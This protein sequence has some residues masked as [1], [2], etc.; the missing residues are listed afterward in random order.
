MEC[1]SWEASGNKPATISLDLP[2]LQSSSSLGTS[3]F[4]Q[5]SGP[6]QGN[7]FWWVFRAESIRSL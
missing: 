3:G 6:C 5:L 7:M 1:S 4:F 2:V